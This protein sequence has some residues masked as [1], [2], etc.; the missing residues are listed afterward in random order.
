MK[1]TKAQIKAERLKNLKKAREVF[2]KK[3]KGGR[4]GRGYARTKQSYNNNINS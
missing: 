1:K 3:K 2:K 4:W